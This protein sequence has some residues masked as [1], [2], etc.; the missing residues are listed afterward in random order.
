MEDK[1]EVTSLH[2]TKQPGSELSEF[3]RDHRYTRYLRFVFAAVGSVPWVGAL[4]AASAALHAEAEQGKV[5]EI[6]RL[7][8]E[9]HNAR[10]EDMSKTIAAMIERMEQ[11]GPKAQER[12]Q[13]EEYLGLVRYGFRIWDEASTVEKRERVRRVLTNAAG[14]KLCSDDIVRVFLDWIRKY[15]EIHFRVITCIHKQPGAT[16][17]DV[18][19]DFYGE[20]V[21][22][23]SAEAD[24]F[25]LMFRDLST[26]G[27]IRQHRETTHDGQFLARHR[28][29]AR[30]RGRSLIL[31]S[32]FDDK[33]PHELTELGTQFIHYAMN[34]IV[35]RVGM[36]A[37]NAAQQES[38]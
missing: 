6:I 27:V 10:I 37:S 14:T 36:S 38:T 9:E 19:E 7:W 30:G 11:I 13:E 25:K 16:R 22:E 26:G 35:P 24:L 5:N 4:M 3:I 29:S 31:E 32:A 28:S 17:A 34:E 8:C 21:R 2:Q 15:D 18:W 23:N 20:E 1:A 12:V 33:K